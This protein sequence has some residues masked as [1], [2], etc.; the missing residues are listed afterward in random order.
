[1]AKSEK[2]QV[3]ARSLRRRGRRGLE[4]VGGRAP[5]VPRHLGSAQNEPEYWLWRITYKY[6][7]SKWP[8]RKNEIL[9]KSWRC[10]RVRSKAEDSSD[11]CQALATCEERPGNGAA[12]STGLT[13]DSLGHAIATDSKKQVSAITG[14]ERD[15]MHLIPLNQVHVDTGLCRYRWALNWVWI[16]FANSN[17]KSTITIRAEQS[18]SHHT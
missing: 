15:D 7:L 12:T 13:L 18:I 3:A 9:I 16:D 6:F 5:L 17:L 11:N 10:R 2:E 14:T 4:H 1:M 8:L